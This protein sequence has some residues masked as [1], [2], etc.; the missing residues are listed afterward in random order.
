M[1]LIV[2]APGGI[3]SGQ[4]LQISGSKSESNRL[5]ILRALFPGLVLNNL[6]DSDDVQ[7]MQAGLSSNAEHIDI[8]HAGT[9][10]RFLTAYYASL[11]GRTVTLTG[12]SRMQERPIR[13]LVEALR[14]L[15]A[16]I[17]Y[18]RN[19]GYPPLRITGRS[20]PGSEVHIPAHISS[21]YISALLLL[22]ASLPDGLTLHLEGLITSRPYIEMTL[23]LLTRLGF[24]Y[25]FKGNTI[26][27]PRQQ[28]EGK[29]ILTVE[30]DWSSASYYYS[31]I[32]MSEPG[33]RLRLKFFYT[34]SLQGDRAVAEIYEPL[35]VRTV[36]NAEGIQLEKINGARLETIDLDLK[37]TPDLA[38]TLAVTCFGMGLECRLRGLHTLKIKETDRLLALQNELGKLG[39]D[40]G[41]TDESLHL[42]P[43][44]QIFEGITVETYHDHRMAMAFAPLGLRTPLTIKDA[45]VVSKSYPDFWEHLAKLGFDLKQG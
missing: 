23:S 17:D 41:I 22:A 11:P 4:T 15:G 29:R 7:A 45:G 19:E 28:L 21:Q 34:D 42:R 38:Q 18:S 3:Q 43:A 32:A 33:T 39:A 9:T 30:S 40:I 24:K 31:I 16:E 5:L 36:F 26:R 2:H 14:Q 37:D 25:E 13:I 20:L 27:V 10:M 35:G 6:G 12:S 44:E 1:D 8:G